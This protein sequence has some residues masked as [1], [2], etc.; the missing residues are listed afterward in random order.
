MNVYRVYP[1]NHVFLI[2]TNTMP[3]QMPYLTIVA[4]DEEATRRACEL[5]MPDL[6]TPAPVNPID[7]IEFS[8][9][10]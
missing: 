3:V 1:C 7:R 10:F 6:L 2:K 9:N 5:L 8:K 4:D